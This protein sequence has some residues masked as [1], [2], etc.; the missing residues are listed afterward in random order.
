MNKTIY[1]I[2]GSILLGTLLFFTGRCTKECPTTIKEVTITVPEKTGSFPNPT[3]LKPISSDIKT[4]IQLRDTVI[5]IPQVN[6]ELMNKYLALEQENNSNKRD[7]DRFK[8]YA[9]AISI[10]EYEQTFDNDD[11]SLKVKAKT[12]GKLL[13]L[14]IPE[15]KVKSKTYSTDV[16]IPKPKEKVFSL[17]IG[18]GL[19]TTKDLNKLDPSIH[20]DLINKKGNILSGSY[21]VDGVIGVKYSVNLFNIK[22]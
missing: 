5:E 2:I 8:M 15:Y 6:Q 20:L 13:E 14:L 18:A 11:V 9:D 21:S 19:T 12:E 10:N 22:K 1:I 16:N 3:I 7:L 17:N 4:V